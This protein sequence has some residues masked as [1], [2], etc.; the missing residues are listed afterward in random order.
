MKEPILKEFKIIQFKKEEK[1]KEQIV[2]AVSEYTLNIKL[3]NIPVASLVCLPTD[4]KELA[5]GYLISEGLLKNLDEIDLIKEIYPNIF[6]NTKKEIKD[7]ELYT[8][9]RSS[10]CVGIKQTW[11]Q[12]VEKIE[13]FSLKIDINTIFH[14]QEVLNKKCNI[15]KTS[16]GT[17]SAATFSWKGD[18]IAF[19]EDVGR[20]N[21]IDKVIGY[22][23]L[24]KINSQSCFLVS[25]GRQSA[26][27]ILKL[28]RARIPLVVSNT[29]P[30]VQ[31]IELARNY[32]VT[33]ICFARDPKLSVYA[34]EIRI[35]T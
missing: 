20:H 15:W 27:M 7:I 16:G 5:I 4:L 9:L 21:A 31:G 18:L 6:I 29:A 32:G 19:Y 8:E 22:M 3:N 14:A 10:G 30:M 23:Y 24:N 1:T 11:E 35:I 25:T 13:D 2:K 28:I 34:N 33:L 12:N 17:H 26:G